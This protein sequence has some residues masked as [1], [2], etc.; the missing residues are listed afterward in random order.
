MEESNKL[1]ESRVHYNYTYRFNSFF[2]KQKYYYEWITKKYENKKFYKNLSEELK[3][4]DSFLDVKDELVS[5]DLQDYIE[6]LKNINL[7]IEIE[8][9]LHPFRLKKIEFKKEYIE[10]LTLFLSN[11]YSIT[12]KNILQIE[13]ISRQLCISSCDLDKYIKKAHK[14]N[15]MDIE[16]FIEEI[17]LKIKKMK[18]TEKE[19]RI[20][21]LDFMIF[22]FYQNSEMN[23]FEKKILE[24][25]ETNKR[26]IR[27]LKKEIIKNLGK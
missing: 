6:E 12:S 27:Y 3:N 20:L 26:E 11:Y 13:K 22:N 21:K 5:R 4:F 14:E 10:T 16:K 2:K 23:Y 19:I 8:K 1:Y 7:N 24:G 9:N 15:K 17:L 25:L 18:F